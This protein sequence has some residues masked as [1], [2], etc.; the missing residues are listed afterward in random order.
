MR[1]VENIPF[2]K[3]FYAVCD[4]QMN[5]LDVNNAAVM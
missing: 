2:C 1:Q 3:H 4:R 5:Q